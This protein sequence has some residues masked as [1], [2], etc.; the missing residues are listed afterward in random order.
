[1][2]IKLMAETTFGSPHLSLK[3]ELK[4]VMLII[5]KFNRSCLFLNYHW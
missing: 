1:M 3:N 5:G 2:W 4:N